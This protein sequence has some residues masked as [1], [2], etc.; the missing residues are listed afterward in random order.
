MLE[1]KCENVGI[2]FIITEES[3]TSKIDHFAKEEMKHQEM[4]SG[5]RIYRGLFKSSTNQVINADVNGAL[6]ILRKV[7]NESHFNEIVDRGHVIC[8]FKI[9]I[10]DY[11]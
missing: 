11:K 6:G 9:N 5:K 7:I 10:Y 2:N 8:P 3:Y 4:Y 1:Y